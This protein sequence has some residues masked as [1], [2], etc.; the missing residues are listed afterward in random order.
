VPEQ[1]SAGV[2]TKLSEEP[3]AETVERLRRVMEDRGFTVFNVIDHSAVAERAGVRIP[4]SKLV[5]FGKPSVGDGG[6]ARVA[7]R[8]VG[9]SAQGAGLG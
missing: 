3:V 5:M 6:D 2:I 9:Y 7:S 1:Y 8:C 4:D